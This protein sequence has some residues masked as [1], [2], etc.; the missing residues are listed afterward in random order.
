MTECQYIVERLNITEQLLSSLVKIF[1]GSFSLEVQQEMAKAFVQ[2]GNRMYTLGETV[3]EEGLGSV[4]QSQ[5]ILP[6][7]GSKH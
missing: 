3:R 6:N 1:G 7:L 5:L 4:D 2:A